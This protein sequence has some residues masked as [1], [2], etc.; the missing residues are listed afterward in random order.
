MRHSIFVKSIALLALS[1]VGTTA[2]AHTDIPLRK[3]KAV[4]PASQV[5]MLDSVKGED[6]KKIYSYNDYGYI[7]SVMVYHKDTDWTLD[8]GA[9]Y[10]QDYVF[11]ADGQ[12]TSRTRYN[13]DEQ[14]KRVSVEDKGELVVKDG[15]TWEYTYERFADGKL[16][17]V[18]AKAYD[19]WGNL[20][21]DMEYETDWSTHED[22]IS[23]YEE[24]R[25]SGPA[26][27]GTHH[28]Y[29]FVEAYRTYH[30]EAHSWDYRTSVVDELRVSSC[31]MVTWEQSEGKLIRKQFTLRYSDGEVTIG[32]V[33]EHLTLVWENIYGLNAAGTRPVSM[34]SMDI[35]DSEQTVTGYEEYTWDDSNRLTGRVYKD[36]YD[37]KTKRLY[38]YTYADNYAKEMSLMDAVYAIAYDLWLYPEDEMCQFGRLATEYTEY[39]KYDEDDELIGKSHLIYTW[40]ADGQLTLVEGTDSDYEYNIDSDKWELVTEKGEEH[41]F[42]NA[43]NHMSHLISVVEHNGGSA[44]EYIKIEFIYDQAGRWTGEKEYSGESFDGPW[45]LDYESNSLRSRRPALKSAPVIDDMSEGY[46]RIYGNDGIFQTEGTYVV[47]D[48]KIASGNYSQYIVSTASI[49]QNPEL[50][51][52]DPVVPFEINDDEADSARGFW[53]YEWNRESESWELEVG[54]DFDSHIYRSGNDIICDTYNIEQV[55]ICTTTY[56]LDESKRLIRQSGSNCEITYEYL[57]DDSNYLL[58]SVTTIDGKRSVLHYYYSLHDY[59]SPTGIDSATAADGNDAYYDLQGR[60]ITNPSAHGIYI[61]NGRKVVK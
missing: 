3:I 37:S 21:I 57:A 13:V 10:L 35:S 17:P 41:Y 40:N 36:S 18:T 5:N 46:H 51:Y 32:N 14:G 60:R 53:M 16:H 55:K 48:G 52:T 7:T 12:C 20:T 30:V 23:S 33:K 38:T 34:T 25:Y 6:Y 19:K 28:E 29:S 2:Y 26:H 1:C 8:T 44:N 11:N 9:S 56:S 45:T 61:R 39:R 31:D 24:T 22:Y 43:D 27:T 59:I 49:P 47:K 42:Y 4:K 54:P 58:E 50:Y 15:L